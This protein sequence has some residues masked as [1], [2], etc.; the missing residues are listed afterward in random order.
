[1]KSVSVRTARFRSASANNFSGNTD[2]VH[3]G[4]NKPLPISI[5][6][7]LYSCSPWWTDVMFYKIKLFITKIFRYIFTTIYR[8]RVFTDVL[9]QFSVVVNK[10]PQLIGWIWIH[11]SQSII[12]LGA[13]CLLRYELKFMKS[14][15]SFN[16][17]KLLIFIFALLYL[18]LVVL[19]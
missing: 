10:W 17:L 7:M 6:N 4:N 11:F 8:S 18:C 5:D 14:S 12:V 9:K 2:S 16:L 15:I 19:N 3:L 1:M 13:S